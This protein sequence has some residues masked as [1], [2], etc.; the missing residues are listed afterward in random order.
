MA[1]SDEEPL[2]AFDRL[3]QRRQHAAEVEAEVVRQLNLKPITAEQRKELSQ[4]ARELRNQERLVRQI[5]RFR[6]KNLDE[7]YSRGFDKVYAHLTST[8]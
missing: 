2:R 4:T 1:D 7:Y 6:D 8:D 5:E 3:E